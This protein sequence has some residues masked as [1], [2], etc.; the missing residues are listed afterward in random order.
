MKK[1]S[2]QTFAFLLLCCF[3]LVSA[4]SCQKDG[5]SGG[6]G[7]TGGGNNGGGGGGPVNPPAKSEVDFYLTTGSQSALLDKQTTSLVFGTA[8]NVNPTI[9]V[10]TMQTFQTVDGFGFCL[11][12]GS[13]SLIAGLPATTQDNLLKELFG[14]D[15]SSISISYLRVS[16]G[17]SDLSATVY[18]Y[19][20]VPTGETDPDLLKFSLRKDQSE[21]VPLP[22]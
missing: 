12:D 20:D 19:N 5:G 10:D 22:N 21:V 3:V 2:P 4:F 6:G 8:A 11:T 1:R 17:A 7:N 18:T 9:T 14:K 15:S 13:A 16:I